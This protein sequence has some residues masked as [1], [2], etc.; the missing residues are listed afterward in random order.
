[1]ADK[2]KSAPN[3]T[4]ASPKKKTQAKSKATKPAPKKQVAK[5]ATRKKAA[6]RKKTTMSTT[7]ADI[8][9]VIK[10]I[11]PE[12]IIKT[13]SGVAPIVLNNEKVKKTVFKKLFGWLSKSK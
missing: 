4:K 6:P 2:K 1:M 10:E 11:V 12:E 8:D 7:I 9:V 5:K 13:F 3:K